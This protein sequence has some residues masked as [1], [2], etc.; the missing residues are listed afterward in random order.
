VWI[1][2]AVELLDL[3]PYGTPPTTHYHRI[4]A[5]FH[6]PDSAHNEFYMLDK[7]GQA[8]GM[9]PGYTPPD[10]WVV[11]MSKKIARSCDARHPLSVT[12]ARGRGVIYFEPFVVGGETIS[13]VKAL[14][15]IAKSLHENL[16]GNV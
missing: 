15:C 10:P 3:D 14:Y 12:L 16:H 6:I 2:R 13:D 8:H 4:A 1:F 5:T 9:M 7:N 11:E